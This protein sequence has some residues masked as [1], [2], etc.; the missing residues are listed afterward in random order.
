MGDLTVRHGGGPVHPRGPGSGAGQSLS[1]D[2]VEWG[3]TV[4][5]FDDL[6]ALLP[7]GGGPVITSGVF[8][9]SKVRRQGAGRRYF[10]RRIGW[11]AQRDRIVLVIGERDLAPQPDGRFKN[12]G[13]WNVVSVQEFHAVEPPR[14]RVGDVPAARPGIS[15][16]SGN[17]STGPDQVPS[18]EEAFADAHSELRFL[19][20]PIRAT[21]LGRVGQPT[22]FFAETIQYSRNGTV[23]HHTASVLRMNDTHA[24]VVLASRQRGAVNWQAEQLQYSFRPA[25]SAALG[26]P[27]GYGQPS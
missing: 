14:R 4:T 27:G 8:T 26:S 3:G 15:G 25:S 23:T 5:A 17:G 19:P 20:A 16:D 2:E 10:R 24:V 1:L 9:D 11:Q 12:A 13:N 18:G 6:N 7:P 22:H 21:V